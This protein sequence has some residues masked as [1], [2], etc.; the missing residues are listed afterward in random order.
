MALQA[1]KV[2]GAFEKRAPG[3]ELVCSGGSRVGISLKRDE[4]HLH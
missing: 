3:L 1:R 4:S 2:S